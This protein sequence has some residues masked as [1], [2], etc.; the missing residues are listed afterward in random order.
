M[1]AIR[2]HSVASGHSA[3]VT[4]APRWANM[5]IGALV[6]IMEG[7]SLTA[8]ASDRPASSPAVNKQVALAAQ[9]TSAPVVPGVTTDKVKAALPEFEKL[10]TELLKKTGVPGLAIAVVHQDQLVYA[11]GFGVREVGKSDALDADT[12]FQL[13]SVSKPLGSTVMQD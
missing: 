10:I 3:P 12:V 4:P 2:I 7:L 6:L 8:C 11:K 1:H 5:G 9:P 13:A